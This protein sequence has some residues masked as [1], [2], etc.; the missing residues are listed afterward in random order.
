VLLLATSA[1]AITLNEVIELSR[2][3]LADEV[4]IALIEQQPPVAD[5]DAATVLWLKDAGVSERVLAALVRHARP[6][7]VTLEPPDQAGQGQGG[8]AAWHPAPGPRFQPGSSLF[9]TP[10]AP[11]AAVMASPVVVPFMIVVV[12]GHAQRPGPAP[13]SSAPPLRQGRF[14]NDGFNRFINDGFTRFINDGVGP[15]PPGPAPPVRR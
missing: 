8:H 1:Q 11:S 12:P 15:P 2:A 14:V 13:A 4:I 10:P 5:L 3:R 6:A 9:W 7:S